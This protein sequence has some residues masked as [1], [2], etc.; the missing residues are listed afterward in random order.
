MTSSQLGDLSVF[1]PTLRCQR[2]CVGDSRSHFILVTIL[3]GHCAYGTNLLFILE[4]TLIMEQRNR[5]PLV[6]P[7]PSSRFYFLFM[8]SFSNFDCTLMSKSFKICTCIQDDILFNTTIIEGSPCPSI[9]INCTMG[10]CITVV[11]E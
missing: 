5:L 11:C 4:I 1:S 2:C 6:L 7:C 10:N 9:L 3:L 8:I